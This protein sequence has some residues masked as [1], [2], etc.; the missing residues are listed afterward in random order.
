MTADYACSLS[1]GPFVGELPVVLRLEGLWTKGVHVADSAR[2]AAARARHL[3][4]GLITR[5]TLRAAIAVEFAFPR[6]TSVIVQPSF[7]Y[8]FNWRKT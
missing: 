2:I 6:N 3:N 8:T 1:R 4:S 7:Y 5:D